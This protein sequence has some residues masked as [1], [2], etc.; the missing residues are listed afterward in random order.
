MNPAEI[1]FNEI[2]QVLEADGIDKAVIKSFS[3]T[4]S[5]DDETFRCFFS[6]LLDNFDWVVENRRI[7]LAAITNS[8]RRPVMCETVKDF[9]PDHGRQGGEIRTK[10]LKAFK[11]GVTKKYGFMQ[12]CRLFDGL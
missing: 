7:G 9:F 10:F 3:A 8:S 1:A 4:E 12:C 11:K 2:K 5:W 6:I